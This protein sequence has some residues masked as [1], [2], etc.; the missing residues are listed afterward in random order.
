MTEHPSIE[1]QCHRLQ[2]GAFLA[3][4]PSLWLPPWYFPDYETPTSVLSFACDSGQPEQAAHF[5]AVGEEA[6][7]GRGTCPDP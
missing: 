7:R 3:W 1:S 2:S 5:I 4:G 6:P